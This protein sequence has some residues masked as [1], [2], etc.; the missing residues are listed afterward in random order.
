MGTRMDLENRQ[1]RMLTHHS[2][3]RKPAI[4]VEERREGK[5]RLTGVVI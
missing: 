1:D 5:G 4:Y 2:T 3:P